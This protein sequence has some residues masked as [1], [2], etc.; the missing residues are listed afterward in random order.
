MVQNTKGSSLMGEKE[1]KN[2]GEE[3]GITCANDQRKICM[4]NFAFNIF[5]NHLD[6]SN[7]RKKPNVGLKVMGQSPSPPTY[8]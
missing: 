5:F 7:K 4:S 8:N 1:K 3:G 2:E 6:L